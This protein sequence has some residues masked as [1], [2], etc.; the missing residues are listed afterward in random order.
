MPEEVG[1][2]GAGTIGPCTE[3]CDQIA[4]FGARQ[5]GLIGEFVEWCAE[6]SDDRHNLVRFGRKARCNR[7]RIIAANDGAEITA[8][9]ELVMSQ[10]KCAQGDYVLVQLSGTYKRPIGPPIRG[11]SE[12]TPDYKMHGIMLTVMKDNKNVGNYFLKLTGPAKTVAASEE[13]LRAS[14]A[15][16]K[17][18]EEKFELP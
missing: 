8:G 4:H 6:A 14:I 1:G 10:G 9:R 12:P 7:H 2:A 16:D 15:A 18:K 11:K 5:A 3:D 13:A 17:S